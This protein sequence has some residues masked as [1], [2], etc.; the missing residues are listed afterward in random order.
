MMRALVSLA[1]LS[2][3]ARSASAQINQEMI[4]RVAAG[5]VTE[6]RASW[7]GF[8][9]ED[10]TDALQAAINSGAEKL[11]VEDMGSPWIVRPITLAG[12]QEIV[13]EEGVEILAKRGEFHALS[14]ALFRASGVENL[15][16]R[17]EGATFRMWR[18]DYANPD[19]YEKAEWRHCL[20]IAG[21]T[22]VA[23]IGLTLTESGGDGIYLGGGGSGNRDITIRGVTCDA[24][25][26]QG[27][28]VISAENLLIEDC[29]LSNTKGTPPEAGIDF[30]PNYSTNRLVNIV[31]RNCLSTGNNTSGYV[32]SIRSLDAESEPVSIRFENCRS[33]DDGV[34][35]AWTATTGTL[36]STP[37]GRI[38]FVDCVLE[39]CRQA[40]LTLSGAAERDL[41]RVENCR[42]LDCAEE[43][44]LVS[45]IMFASSPGADIPSGGA[46][47]QDVT[48]RDSLDR[49]P[50][51]YNNS[52]GVPLRN[53]R[54]ALILDR[55]GEPATVALTTQKLAE[56][57][58][59]ATIAD[60]PRMS[61]EGL[62]LQPRASVNPVA[63][64]E[65]RWPVIRGGASYLLH[66]D[67]G[68]EVSFIVDYMQVGKYRGEP[69]PVTVTSAGGEEVCEVTAPF[70]ER[71]TVAFTAAETGVY[72]VSFNP[73]TNRC[74]LADASNPMAA[75]IGENPL[76]LILSAGRLAF[77]VPPGTETFGVRVAGQGAGEAIK[78]TL[79]DPDG[80]VFGTVDNQFS[81]Y[82]FEVDGPE[83]SQGG[84][85]TLVLEAPSNTTWED[86][87]V[88]LRGVPPL[89]AP[90]GAPLLVP[91]GD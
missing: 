59:A 62:E 69:M 42:V 25:Y 30:E 91:T 29:V 83:A 22:N 46:V 40:G 70:K 11:I 43:T 9:A 61:L 75:V 77:W 32:V 86:H 33:V 10:V 67:A 73:G 27:I 87:S 60:I 19:L 88:E 74:R 17:G 35:A 72:R 54:G 21:C 12:N 24:N 28:S 45:P 44:P 81:L 14:A 38:E 18:D 36:E 55:D 53:V 47:L 6:A 37:E 76:K 82:Q 68:D 50:I 51:G 66:A 8:D 57:V 31:V 7:W 63:P 56:W 90:A 65:A 85:W 78:A 39:G 34:M 89:L 1:V 48:V 23:V 64:Q 26:R 2:M 58:P 15:V 80:E 41:F 20:Y 13:F 84:E 16:L 4:D 71:T 52:A 3:L 5:E 79:I 49:P